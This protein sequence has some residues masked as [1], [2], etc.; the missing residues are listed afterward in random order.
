MSVQSDNACLITRVDVSKLYT[1]YPEGINDLRLSNIGEN[2]VDHSDK[3]TV[4][5]RVT[6][7]LNNG[8]DIGP[9]DSGQWAKSRNAAKSI[10]DELP[11]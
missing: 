5:E 4:L 3:H 6:G 1:E 8:D 9:S 7:V 2:A 11:Y 10:T